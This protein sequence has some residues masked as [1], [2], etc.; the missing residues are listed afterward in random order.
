M[1]G[2]LRPDLDRARASEVQRLANQGIT[3]GS[4]AFQRAMERRDRADTDA[5]MQALIGAMGEQN[6]LFNQGIAG[7]QA[8]D[9]QRMQQY[10]EAI[11]TR[12]LPMQEM[13]KMQQAGGQVTPNLAM[14][15]FMS[16]TN[17]QG[18]DYSGAAQNQYQAAMN[19]Y[20]AKQA[21]SGGM[22]KGLMS[23]GGTLLGGPL[24][25]ALGSALGGAM[26]GTGAS[27]GSSNFAGGLVNRMGW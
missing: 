14:P 19:D 12:D 13:L 5:S 22:L 26:G 10:G 1:M 8:A 2:R 25:G 16:A 4:D 7:N 11:D 24:G 21:Q 15:G 17:G 23:V 18:V 9:R 27:T 20:N 3:E 6:T